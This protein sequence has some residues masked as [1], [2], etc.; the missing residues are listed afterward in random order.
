MVLGPYLDR[1]L[2]AAHRDS[3]ERGCPVAY[4][5]S[6]VD[7]LPEIARERF[8]RGT[9]VLSQCIG[10]LVADLPGPGE[11]PGGEVLLAELVGVLL[12]ARAMAGSPMSDRLLEDA[13]G[14]LRTRLGMEA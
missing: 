12:M 6:D 10:Q 13:R 9:S 1:Y 2:S 8:V 3:R 11:R 5:A 7:R 4:L 14:K